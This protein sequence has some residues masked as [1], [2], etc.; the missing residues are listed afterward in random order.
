MEQLQS[1]VRKRAAFTLV[2]LLVVIGIIAVLIAILLPALTKAR[3][4]AQT[5]ACAANLRSI[6]QATQIFASQNNGYL[7]G[8]VYSTS[9]FLFKEPA[10]GSQVAGNALFPTPYSN[11]NCP[12]IIH[13]SDWC[14]PLARIMGVKFNEGSDRQARGER[15]MTM[16]DLRQF[17]C[18]NNE[19]LA[20]EFGSNLTQYV[21]TGAMISYNTAL[22]FLVTRTTASVNNGG[23]WGMSTSRPE[24]NVPASYNTKLSK[25]GDPSRKVFI[26]DGSKFSAGN[27]S[28]QVSETLPDA[29]LN[30]TG[31]LGGPF[32]D[33]GPTRFTRA[34]NRDRVPGN[35]GSGI[36]CRTFWARHGPSLPRVGATP[37]TYRFNVG[38][39]DGHVETL[40]DLE[41]S[42]P[43]MWYPKG[44]ELVVT[45]GGS[46]QF[47]EDV[48]KKYFGKDY[49]MSSPFIVP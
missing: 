48:Y 22:G 34:W 2:E 1:S 39:F 3:R 35:G 5:V 16:R 33:Q 29:D 10:A 24:W 12:G 36:D 9:R 14:S 30:F 4:S 7:P 47:F 26:A 11:D 46:G 45:T 19:F 27:G 31:S 13:Y 25:V 6:L 17:R 37:D 18:P 8:S 40:G 20:P 44:T 23:T 38:F 32:A 28:P 43:S 21:T 49:P 15:Y 42:N 41:G